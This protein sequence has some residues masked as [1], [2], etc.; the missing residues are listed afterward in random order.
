M[1]DMNKLC[2]EFILNPH[3]NPVN[4]Q[5][6]KDEEFDYYRY[7]CKEIGQ[8]FVPERS[9]QLM[10]NNEYY[11]RKVCRDFLEDN[12]I[13]PITGDKLFKGTED[14]YNLISLC[15]Y[16]GFDTSVSGE[17]RSVKSK[18]R[19]RNVLGELPELP[20]KKELFNKKE[21]LPIP[22][23]ALSS[24]KKSLPVPARENI[25]LDKFKSLSVP[26][27]KRES[28]DIL[29]NLKMLARELHRDEKTKRIVIDSL[30]IILEKNADR[31]R[32]GNLILSGSK[33]RYGLKQFIFDLLIN[34]EINLVMRILG[35]FRLQYIDIADLLFDFPKYA[36][37]ESLLF[38]YFMSGPADTDWSELSEIMESVNESWIL[39]EK[40]NLLILLLGVAT[41]TGNEFLSEILIEVWRTWRDNAQEELD[42]ME[43][44]IEEKDKIIELVL[45]LD[46]LSI[47]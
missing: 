16:Y 33:N 1:E 19:R 5:P 44:D 18:S 3:I 8:E 45:M 21:L 28:D 9:L 32:N 13:N 29:T 6:I 46:T 23:N 26:A 38:N 24:P 37:D 4:N 14:Y 25:S 40:L 20:T 47:R 35:F 11:G 43:D 39:E 34:N 27:R 7:M 22:K 31:D 2:A 30:P 36:M 41:S 15:D 10:Y 17:M 42:E 12:T